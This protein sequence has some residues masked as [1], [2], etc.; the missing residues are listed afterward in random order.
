MG[1]LDPLAGPA[2]L[3]SPMT[4]RAGG[5]IQGVLAGTVLI[6]A[7][8][9]AACSSRLSEED[10]QLQVDAGVA[11]ALAAIPA[12]ATPQP[13]PTPAPT[14]TPASLPTPQPA[15]TPQPTSTP[16]PESTPQPTATPARIATPQPTATPQPLRPTPT[17]QPTATP[18]PLRPTPTPQ[19]FATP[20]PTALLGEVYQRSHGAVFMAVSPGKTG[21][22]FLFEPGLLLTNEHV[23]SG[24]TT[25][26][27]WDDLGNMFTGTVVASD[28]LRDLALIRINPGATEATPLP[29]AESISHNEVAQPL[30]AIGYSNTDAIDP[31]GTA[32]ANVGVLTRVYILDS[33]FGEGFEMDAPVDPGDSGGPVLNREGEVVGVSRGV[34][35]S[36]ASGQRVIGTFLAISI[37]EVHLALPDLRAGISR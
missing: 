30:L 21:T 35:V 16:A 29:L 6:V 36:T 25:V 10:V 28:A 19:P 20:Q 14:A 13:T 32:G 1:A 26:E 17:P 31:I 8:I 5:Y 4:L 33:S 12:A 11:T 3:A 22:A 18:Q 34:V 24:N 2:L 27:L 15:P 37:G 7:F 9:L 23:I